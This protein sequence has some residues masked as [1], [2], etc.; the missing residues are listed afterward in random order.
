MT[1]NAW[2]EKLKVGDT[3]FLDVKYARGRYTEETVDKVTRTQFVVGHAR[4]RRDNGWQVGGNK[5][6]H[7]VLRE[8]TPERIA[9]EVAGRLV[10]EVKALLGRT[11]LTRWPH[12]EVQVLHDLLLKY[13][14]PP[15]ENS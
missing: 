15:K 2:L 3:V 14:Q 11:A 10:D 4:F 1:D 12:S 9:A 6:D 8:P 7:Y 5:W 13:A